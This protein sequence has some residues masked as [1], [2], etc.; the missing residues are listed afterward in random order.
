MLLG[1]ED[2]LAKAVGV[3][4]KTH[5]QRAVVW[6]EESVEWSA[7]WPKYLESAKQGTIA[8]VPHPNIEISS[9]AGRAHRGDG[10]GPAEV[11]LGR[12][13]YR[14][15]QKVRMQEGRVP[16]CVHQL[17]FLKSIVP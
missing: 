12:V 6:S 2:G 1:L 10:G 5:Q 11:C 8:L 9:R 7:R 3:I 16:R 4:D 14:K 13:F 17:L 15:R